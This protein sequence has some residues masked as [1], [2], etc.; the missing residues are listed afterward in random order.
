MPDPSTPP[1]AGLSVSAYPINDSVGYLLSRVRSLMTNLVTQRT[2]TELGITGT[3]ASMLFMLAV[4]K[5]S[6][7][8]ELAREYAIDASAVTRLLDRVEKRGLLSRVRSHEDRRVVRLELTDE[9]RE[10]AER[11]PEIFISVLDRLLDGFTPEEVGFLKS[12]LRRILSNY[13]GETSS[14]SSGGNAS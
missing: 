10:L 14:G 3:Q 8:A 4:G 13:C 11:M 12:M 2:Q 1:P 6:T 9:G 7:A 5:C